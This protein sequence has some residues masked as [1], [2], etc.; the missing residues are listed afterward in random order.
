MNDTAYLGKHVKVI[1]D[2]PLGTKHP[3]YGHIYTLNYGYIPDTL[4]GDGEEV[5][6]YIIGVFE[7]LETYEGYV[8]ALIKREDDVEDKLVVCKDKGKYSKEAIAA[9][10]E[11]QERFFTSEIIMAEV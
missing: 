3:Q 5:D 1:I 10:V 11:F 4:A 7:P 8:I 9:L 6:A 2:R